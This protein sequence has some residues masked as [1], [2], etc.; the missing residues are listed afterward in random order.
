VVIFSNLSYVAREGTTAG[1]FCYNNQHYTYRYKIKLA[2]TLFTR[3][4]LVEHS[5]KGINS[6]NVWVK[7]QRSY[8]QSAHFPGHCPN[9]LS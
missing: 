8:E 4:S 6:L 3:K 2:Q 9:Y 5:K 7:D 1:D